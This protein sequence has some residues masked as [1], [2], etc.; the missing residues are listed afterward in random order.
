MAVAKCTVLFYHPSMEKLA[1]KVAKQLELKCLFVHEAVQ[2]CMTTGT[3][4][5]MRVV[6]KL[7]KGFPPALE[8]VLSI[9]T[10]QM[11]SGVCP[12]EEMSI[13]VDAPI[14]EEQP[15]DKGC[16]SPVTLSAVSP[17]SKQEQGKAKQSLVGSFRRQASVHVCFS[18]FTQGTNNFV[19]SRDG[20]D[21]D[22]MIVCFLQ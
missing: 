21:P 1:K 8:D 19:A 6:A 13:V 15:V 4:A 7:E 20:S 2:A 12:G 11:K 9:V 10:D 3:P 5:G 17:E 18:R 14:A 16:V 22:L